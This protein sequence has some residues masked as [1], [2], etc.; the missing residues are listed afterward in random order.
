MCC[1]PWLHAMIKIDVMR[2]LHVRR[3][4]N[5]K[6]LLTEMAKRQVLNEQGKKIKKIKLSVI[7]IIWFHIVM[8]FFCHVALH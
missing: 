2:Q 5:E 4:W 3:Y 1:A 8:T 7:A 6:P